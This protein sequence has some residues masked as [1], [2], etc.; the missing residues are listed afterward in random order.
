[1]PAVCERMSMSTDAELIAI[2]HQTNLP[3]E[4]RTDADRPGI[5]SE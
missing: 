3:C 1:M 5:S 2:E 4:M